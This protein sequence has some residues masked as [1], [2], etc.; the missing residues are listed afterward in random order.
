MMKGETM[1]L[2]AL[3]QASCVCTVTPKHKE[4]AGKTHKR[5]HTHDEVAVEE[6]FLPVMDVWVLGNTESEKTP[7]HPL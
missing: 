2:L 5:S 4:K 1:C 7:I 3:C 6:A